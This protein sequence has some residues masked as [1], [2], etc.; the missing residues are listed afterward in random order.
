MGKP[1]VR[2]SHAIISI[3]PAG[4]KEPQAVG[5]ISKFSVKELGE[6]KKSRSMGEQQ[7]TANKTFEGYD[8]SFEGGK[9]DWQLAQLL[10]AQDAAI[11]AGKRAPHFQVK[12]VITYFGD[13]KEEFTYDDVVLFGYNLDMDANDEMSEK[14]E[15][16]CGTLRQKP[17]SS[18][19]ADVEKSATDATTSITAAITA[20]L[21]KDK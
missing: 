11:V 5:E 17:A 2:G 7:V 14:F 18:Q 21:T 19:N 10:H 16:F 9:V 4:A 13:K 20:A 8:L 12:Q 3:T 6:I 1:R 15:G